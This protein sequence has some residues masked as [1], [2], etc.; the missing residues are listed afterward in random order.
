[1]KTNHQVR[2]LMSFLQNGLPLQTAAAKAG[3]TEPTARKYRDGGK[4]PED[5]GRQR[6]WRTRLDPFVEVWPEVEELLKLD[7]GL[8][9]KTIFEE[10]E[11]RYPGRFPQGQLRTLQ[12]RIRDWHAL[13]GPG[14]E[15][16]FPQIHQPGRLCQ[17][18]FTDMSSLEIMIGGEAFRHLCYHFVLTYSNWEYVTLAYS[19]SFE[20]LSEGFQSALWELGAVPAEHRTDNLSAATHELR[21]SRG[22]GFT[23][24]YLEL[25]G[26]YDIEP[27][28]NNPGQGNENGDVESSHHHFKQAVDQRLRLR[29]NRD[30][31]GV[32]Y[33]LEFLR[34]MTRKRNSS[35][36]SL[37]QEELAAMKKLPQR[38][39][40]A[41]RS[42]FVTVTKWSTIR[43]SG[44]V[45]SVPSRLIGERLEAQIHAEQIELL[46]KGRVVER[47]ERLRGNDRQRID[48]R[49]IIESLLKKPGAFARYIYREA[50]FPG[51]EF[52]RCYDAIVEGGGRA[53]ELEYARIL[54]LAARTMESKV[55]AAILDLLGRGQ[56]PSYD[57]VRALVEPPETLV[58]PELEAAVPD[59]AA[60]DELIAS[61]EELQEVKEEQVVQRLEEEVPA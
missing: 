26:H 15:V 46:Y 22:R 32:S 6:V 33:Y 27:S 56:V 3:M 18:D 23:E 10:L 13:E 61:Q 38:R 42:Q 60:Y 41:F 54:H 12:R 36:Q 49:H 28:R 4:L 44:N 34:Q 29:G 58:C 55:T 53:P 51:V 59:L 37:L 17:S 48:Y 7:A 31:A 21:E 35:R 47:L 5:L 52:R 30:F 39:L 50:L 16:F 20:A 8:Q 40:D 25:V 14:K 1:M 45:Y 11:R 9:A 2:L 24:R 57:A 43:I 19:E